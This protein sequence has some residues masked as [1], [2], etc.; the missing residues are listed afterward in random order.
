MNRLS[1]WAA[2]AALSGACAAALAYAA[3]SPSAAG[4][5]ASAAA[6]GA[7]NALG[8]ASAADALPPASAAAAASSSPSTLA[9]DAQSTQ[10]AMNAASAASAA[11]A[12]VAAGVAPTASTVDRGRYLVDAGDCVA[13]HTA[14][15]GQPFTGGRPLKTPFGTVL[16]ANLTPDD[17]TGIGRYTAD[18]FYRALHEG[19]DRD[20]HHLYPAFP[21]NYY[22]QLT[23]QDS[24]AILAYLRSLKPVHHA[25]QRNQLPFPFSVRAIVAG[26][27]LMFLDKGP[28]APDAAKSAAWNRG[29]YLVRGLGHCGACH[30]PKN[31]LGA[32]KHEHELQGG[33]FANLFAPDITPN[34]RSGVGNWSRDELLEF[35]RQGRNAHSAASAEMGEV[36]E[37]ST[38][39]M[40]DADL[41]AIAT[42]LADRPPAPAATFSAPDSATM[43]QGHAIWQDTCSACHQ[44]NGEG[45]PRYFAP[46]KANANLQQADPTTV[47]H[48]ILAGT[49]HAPT[50][51]AP[52]PFSMPPFDWKLN[53]EQVAAVAT[54]AR[55]SWGNAAAPVT[56]SEVAELRAKLAQERTAPAAAPPTS[57]QHPGPLT[58]APAGTDSRDNGGQQ[59]GQPA[60]AASQPH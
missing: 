23:R 47:L 6:A 38:S 30:T 39:R 12:A 14:E 13:C 53:D 56:A 59:A 26:W 54:Y 42:Y 2:V 18:T 16:S 1:R 44:A 27:N 60:R 25:L 29:A 10:S 19:L 3:S 51:A 11:N 37:F 5:P 34:R 4:S 52:T 46:L 58:L 32:P 22:T 55:N 35:L 48:F 43:A 15:G 8:A 9:L 57:M 24:D 41:G 36:A 50:V 28:F 17:E 31:V 33:R 40:S 21:Y 20:G 7:S 45:V 49:R